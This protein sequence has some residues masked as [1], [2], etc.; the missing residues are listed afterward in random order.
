MYQMN[1]Y[2]D[3]KDTALECTYKYK[4][5]TKHPMLGT[6]CQLW[7]GDISK[8]KTLTC[9]GAQIKNLKVKLFSKESNLVCLKN[10]Q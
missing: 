7:R 10:I 3:A 5:Q 1:K 6:N 2:M 4:K 9:N 8:E